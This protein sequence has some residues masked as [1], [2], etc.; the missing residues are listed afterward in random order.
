MSAHQSF[1]SA[2]GEKP[3]W[4]NWTTAVL[5]MMSG[6]TLARLVAALLLGVQSALA[7][8]KPPKTDH[9]HWPAGVRTSNLAPHIASVTN[10]LNNPT[11]S[12]ACGRLTPGR[13]TTS[14]DWCARSDDYAAGT[15]KLHETLVGS[16]IDV[17]IIP[18]A[19]DTEWLE[20]RAPSWSSNLAR[21]RPRLR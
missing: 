1:L 7:A 10:C 21:S 9:A 12:A 17:I 14:A 3:I 15:L 20:G 4:T 13:T 16:E 2:V 11:T 5:G 8:E 19:D 6:P 18:A